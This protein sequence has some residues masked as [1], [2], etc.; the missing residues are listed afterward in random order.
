MAFLRFIDVG[1]FSSLQMASS[2]MKVDA[3]VGRSSRSSSTRSSLLIVCSIEEFKDESI[4]MLALLF[5]SAIM[6][7]GS[8]GNV[9]NLAVVVVAL[10]SA[11]E[12]YK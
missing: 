3:G 6:L 10:F 5:E 9:I 11:R 2:T 8:R 7:L 1:L 4:S 12:L